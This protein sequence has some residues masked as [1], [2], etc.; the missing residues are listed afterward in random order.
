MQI[1]TSVREIIW[2]VLFC[3]HLVETATSHDLRPH[4]IEEARRWLATAH[5]EAQDTR[6]LMSKEVGAQMMVGMSA[7]GRR[8]SHCLL[9]KRRIRHLGSLISKATRR[10]TTLSLWL[11]NLS[12]PLCINLALYY[13]RLV[14]ATPYLLHHLLRGRSF[15]W[16][17][18]LDHGILMINEDQGLQR[19]LD[20]LDS[21]ARVDESSAAA[22]LV[23]NIGGL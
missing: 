20:R 17:H 19:R 1:F 15:S 4:A 8:L 7:A 2:R 16:R 6:P 11:R 14:I 13:Q 21:I 10:R 22:R 5:Q 12:H 23:E 3:S 9:H 18:R